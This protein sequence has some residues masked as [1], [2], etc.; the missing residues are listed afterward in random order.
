MLT[1]YKLAN[2]EKLMNIICSRVLYSIYYAL[3][4]SRKITITSELQPYARADLR[5]FDY[6]TYQG[7][8][9]FEYIMFFDYIQGFYGF[10]RLSSPSKVRIRIVSYNLS[11]ITSFRTCCSDAALQLIIS[12]HRLIYPPNLDSMR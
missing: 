3:H 9:K 12:L 2:K 7:Y 4:G 6:R 8:A 10:D 1:K 5:N 11:I